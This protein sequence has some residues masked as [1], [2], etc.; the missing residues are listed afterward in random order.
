MNSASLLSRL[1]CCVRSTTATESPLVAR[2]AAASAMANRTSSALSIHATASRPCWSGTGSSISI[3]CARR[4][5][6]SARWLLSVRRCGIR[7][8]RVRDWCNPADADRDG[9][10]ESLGDVGSPTKP[11]RD[12][13]EEQHHSPAECGAADES[14]RQDQHNAL[15]S[16]RRFRLRQGRSPAGRHHGR[17]LQRVSPRWTA[18]ECRSAPGHMRAAR[19][20]RSACSRSGCR[21]RESSSICRDSVATSAS[22]FSMRCCMLPMSTFDCS[23]SCS[24]GKLR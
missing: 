9:Q 12:D 22:S 14:R 4:C 24:P 3:A 17:G 16:H 1:P 20:G 8:H 18:A 23:E 6:S 13:G 19:S 15:A 10:L 21:Q 5:R 2:S 7:S 11:V